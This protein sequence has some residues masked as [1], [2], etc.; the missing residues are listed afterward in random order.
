MRVEEFLRFLGMHFDRDMRMSSYVT[1]T[2]SRAAKDLADMRTINVPP[3]GP[4][5]WSR[6]IYASVFQT[7]MLYTA[8]I[9]V[10]IAKV[11]GSQ[12]ETCSNAA[13]NCVH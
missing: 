1:I 12:E 7:I 13:H 8:P 2:A 10:L 3:D 9:L 5:G 11:S 4:R 6:A